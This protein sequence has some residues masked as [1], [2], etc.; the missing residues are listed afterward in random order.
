MS[1]SERAISSGAIDY[2]V[3]LKF[4]IE[5]DADVTALLGP[6]GAT[7]G[8]VLEQRDV[9]LAHPSRNFA[10]TDEAVRIRSIGDENRLT[11]KGP[12]VDMQ[13]KT[14]QEVEVAFAREKGIGR[15]C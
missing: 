12:L 7:A 3:E 1:E 9:Y 13:T 14:R 4:C 6:L 8:A 15:R 5:D 10:V 2:E 11:Y